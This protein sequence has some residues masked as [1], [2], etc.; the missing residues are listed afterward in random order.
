[1]LKRLTKTTAVFILVLLLAFASLLNKTPQV[2]AAGLSSRFNQIS[3]SS[4]SAV[5][6]YLFG[7]NYTDNSTQVG[8][9]VF[10]FCS[11]DPLLSSPCT[12]PTGLDVSG[13]ALAVQTGF[14]GFVIDSADTTANKLV[15]A[16]PGA[17]APSAGQSTYR[18]NNITNPDS[19]GSYYVRLSTHSSLNGSGALIESGGLVF[20][21]LPTFNVVTEVP[22][23]LAFCAAISLSGLDC[24]SASNFAIDFGE[25]STSSTSSGSSQFVVATNAGSGYSVTIDG[26]TMTSGSNIIP[27]LST[28]SASNTGSSQF[29]INLRANSTPSVGADPSTG[30]SGNPTA[31]YNSANQFQYVPGDIIASSSAVDSKKYTVSF[32][33]NIASDQAAGYYATTLSFICL[34]NF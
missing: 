1:M 11:N 34:A 10:E 23:Y 14:T 16:R 19:A 32:I 29:G 4:I 13:A 3:S 6:S 21:I 27:A 7:F 24:S 33:T 30:G 9:V 17:A 8:S 12:V 15:I 25:L 5:A 26:P 20:A 22:P 31:N 28:P 18:F 2:Q